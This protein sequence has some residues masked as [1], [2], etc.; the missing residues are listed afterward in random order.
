MYSMSSCVAVYRIRV[1]YLFIPCAP[2]IAGIIVEPHIQG[3]ENFCCLL[4]IE[5]NMRGCYDIMA[6]WIYLL[7]CRFFV[8]YFVSCQRMVYLRSLVYLFFPGMYL[9]LHHLKLRGV[10]TTV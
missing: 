1:I 9:W 3:T 6:L 10:T 7:N 4:E 5:T 8:N 2:Y